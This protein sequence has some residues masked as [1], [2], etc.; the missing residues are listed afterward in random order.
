M[1]VLHVLLESFNDFFQSMKKIISVNDEQIYL[2]FL[3]QKRPVDFHVFN[4]Y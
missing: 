4:H 1:E 2:L 3:K